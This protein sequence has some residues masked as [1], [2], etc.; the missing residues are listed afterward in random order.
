M[1]DEFVRVLGE[2]GARGK[3]ELPDGAVSDWLDLIEVERQAAIMQLRA[4][5][6]VLM[7]Y[8]RLRTP[9]LPTRVR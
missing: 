5:D 1:P 7:N 8:G 2:N 6:K 3:H 4:C 9:T